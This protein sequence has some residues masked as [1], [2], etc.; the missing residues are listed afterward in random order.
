MVSN[1][2]MM[3]M[4][5]RGACPGRSRPASFSSS[6][7]SSMSLTPLVLEMMWLGSARAP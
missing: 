6:A 7:S 5:S 2:G 1:S 4:D 3:F